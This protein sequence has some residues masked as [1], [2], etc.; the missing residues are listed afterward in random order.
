[1][2]SEAIHIAT[3]TTTPVQ[4]ELQIKGMT[5]AACSAR[6]ESA[7][8]RVAGVEHA[9]VN[10]ATERATIRCTDPSVV[11]DLADAVEIAGF[12]V[13]DVGRKEDAHT[14]D[15]SR[16]E[17]ASL[18]RVLVTAVLSAPVLIVGMLWMHGAPAWARV[19]SALLATPVQF[20]SA[21]PFHRAALRVARHGSADMN[22][23]VSMG[24]WAAYGYSVYAL[25]TG[26]HHLY[27]E[28]A[29]TIT[30]LVLLGRHIELRARG[31]VSQAIRG[32]M[33]LAPE[34]ARVKRGQDWVELPTRDV[35]SG[36]VV[37]VRSGERIA[38][39][40]VILEG[41]GAVDE[42]MLTGE[43][44]PAP[45][46][47][48]DDVVGG[49]VNG[50]GA[51]VIRATRVGDESVLAR[52]VRLVEHA[53]SQKPPVQRMADLVAA[54]FVPVVLAMA[55]ATF[56]WWWLVAGDPVSHALWPAVAVLVIACPCAMGLATP[57]A[58]MAATGRGA[59]LGILVR[60]GSALERAAKVSTVLLDK[61][62]TLTEG[63]PSVTQVV[64]G[65]GRSADDIVAHA[66][67]AEY[68][69][70]HPIA[71]A[72]RAESSRRA[73]NV[74]HASAFAAEPGHGVEALV[75]DVLVRVG[76]IR[77]LDGV[78]EPH[79]L[80]GRI[81]GELLLAARD[82]GASGGAVSVVEVGGDLAGVIAVS[83][84]VTASAAAAVRALRGL[85]L[86]V[87]MVT[88]DGP[89][90]A[91]TV[92]RSVGIEDVAS[93]V[94]PDG[95]ADLVGRYRLD[96]ANVAMVG[97]GINDAPALAAADV[98]IALATGTDIAM[99]TGDVALMRA[100]LHGVADLIRLGRA[101]LSVIKQNLF[102]A[103]VYNVVGI[104]LAA[105]GMLNPMVA[106]GAMG[107]S[108]V[109]VVGNSLRLSRFRGHA[110]ERSAAGHFGHRVS[111]H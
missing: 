29:A 111:R 51:L 8:S 44:W 2:R 80:E 72:I 76:S 96:G 54:R 85:G 70:D 66:C 98:G 102:W 55:L 22:V 37:L 26:A 79:S 7:L 68:G 25:A 95:K 32:L 107:F 13:A 53:Q 108:S 52:I 39:D 67:A 4:V 77:W 1:M 87:V 41:S 42:S 90:A 34:R 103:F 47:V 65:P 10:L 24:T 12:L 64:A 38:T 31:R 59:Q 89:Q 17:T 75:G 81:G 36:D 3:V 100:D 50:L 21:L 28:S 14:S 27:F 35:R 73:I 58:I 69:S 40:G 93:Q 84:P 57:T 48:G 49:S 83:D 91:A 18:R 11:G 5:C 9:S 94:A 74:P 82:L 99:E 109:C 61:T 63:R 106:A 104:P 78:G 92:A 110:Y 97:D 20:W 6:L 30:A 71:E 56:A 23:L 88:G 86:R 19:L 16:D 60:D 15:R 101:T 46:V 33:A 62:G 105:A 45:K 43:S